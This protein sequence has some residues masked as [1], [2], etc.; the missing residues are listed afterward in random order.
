MSRAA[1]VEFAAMLRQQVLVVDPARLEEV[2]ELTLALDYLRSGDTTAAARV[3][4]ERIDRLNEQAKPR[5]VDYDPRL[6]S[7]RGYGT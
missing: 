2:A 5:L 7:A 1:A 6:E 3:L 4:A